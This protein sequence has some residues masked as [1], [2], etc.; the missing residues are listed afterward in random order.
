MPYLGVRKNKLSETLHHEKSCDV[1][2]DLQWSSFI[3]NNNQVK[4]PE[5]LSPELAEEVGIHLGDG[6]LS[7]NRYRYKLSRVC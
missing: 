7:A 5:T 3:K 6:H 2:F 1:S 4:L